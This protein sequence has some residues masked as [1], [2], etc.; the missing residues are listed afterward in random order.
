M[1]RCFF[2][3]FFTLLFLAACV[4]PN[5]SPHSLP[6]GSPVTT[7][8]E[9]G[10]SSTET[11][12]SVE[13]PTVPQN[14]ESPIPLTE[15]SVAMETPARENCPVD[16]SLIPFMGP[17]VWTVSPSEPIGLC[18]LIMKFST[19]LEYSL[20][21]PERWKVSFFGPPE[22]TIRRGWIGFQ[23]EAGSESQVS[24]WG[25]FTD[26]PL[27]TANLAIENDNAILREK[28]TQTVGNKETLITLSVKDVQTKTIQRYF[29]RYDSNDKYPQAR[30]FVFEVLIPTAQFNERQSQELLKDVEAMV[31]SFDYIGSN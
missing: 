25:Q 22:R 29:I 31:A 4:P 8:S 13:M 1:R 7:T 23:P 14:S 3:V 6:E 30:L 28:S 15:T 2:L 24:I 18:K 9:G 20:L 12:L 27:K 26:L 21:F 10:S 19:P 11:L 17:D 16:P 5:S